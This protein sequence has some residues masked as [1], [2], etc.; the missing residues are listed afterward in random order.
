M[1]NCNIDISEI[2]NHIS[3]IDY[4]FLLKTIEPII[5]LYISNKSIKSYRVNIIKFFV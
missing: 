4:S 3:K 5:L 2:A 1:Q